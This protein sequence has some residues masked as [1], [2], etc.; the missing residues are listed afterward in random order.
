MM[1]R[2]YLQSRNRETD[3]E[4]K[5]MDTKWGRRNG[6]NWEIGIDICTLLRVKSTSLVAQTVKNLPA[7]REAQVRSLGWGNK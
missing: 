5:H 3:I 4:N 1:Q 2:T 6:L 7:M